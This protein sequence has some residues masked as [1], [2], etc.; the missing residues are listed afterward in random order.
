MQSEPGKAPRVLISENKGDKSPC[1]RHDSR[2]IRAQTATIPVVSTNEMEQVEFTSFNSVSATHLCSI[3]RK[4]KAGC[5][6]GICRS[7]HGHVMTVSQSVGSSS[8]SSIDMQNL[9][10]ETARSTEPSKYMK[11]RKQYSFKQP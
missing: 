1:L 11:S 3:Q 10:P 7:R 2:D 9:Y 6:G 4:V 8:I 5:G